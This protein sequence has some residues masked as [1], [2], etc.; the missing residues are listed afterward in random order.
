MT[1]YKHFKNKHDVVKHIL[2]AWFDDWFRKLGE[3]S[4]LDC[5]FAEKVG[6]MLEYKLEL[7]EKLSPEFVDDLYHIN[8]ELQTFMDTWYEAFYRRLWE[9]FTDAQKGG[10]IRPDIKPEF[11]MYFVDRLNDMFGDKK[12]VDLYGDYGELTR[13]MF[14]LFYYGILLKPGGSENS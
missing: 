6:K 12:L 11:I 9:F 2:T 8:P 3:V 7:A 1:F 13:E 10:H 4:G 14:N 5:P